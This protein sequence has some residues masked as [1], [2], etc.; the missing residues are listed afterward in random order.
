SATVAPISGAA[1]SPGT[2]RTS[3]PCWLRTSSA[4]SCSSCSFR[5][6]MTTLRPRAAAS[7]D[8]AAPSP[9]DA[10][11]TNAHGPYFCLKS[12]LSLS[13][14]E[15]HDARQPRR[16]CRRLEPVVRPA[17]PR[18]LFPGLSPPNPPERHTTWSFHLR[19]RQT[20]GKE[21]HL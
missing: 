17:A 14:S 2:T 13:R 3:T 20:A 5:A 10:P 16:D 18:E 8:S 15:F 19:L 12:I 1:R 11:A 21:T 4:V 9:I 6:S 7:C